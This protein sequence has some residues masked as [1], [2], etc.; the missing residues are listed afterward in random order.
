[1]A[2]IFLMKTMKLFL[3]FVCY[4][5]T[6]IAVIDMQRNVAIGDALN[7]SPKLQEVIFWLFIIFWI[8]KIVWFIYDHFYLESKERKQT[9]REKEKNGKK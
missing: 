6:G 2:E 7:M 5:G 4:F 1:M 9:M 3:S 8:I